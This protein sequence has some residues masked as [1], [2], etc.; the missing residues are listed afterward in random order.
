MPQ[1]DRPR[2]AMRLVCCCNASARVTMVR[3]PVADAEAAP[4]MAAMI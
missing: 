3:P 1:L 2:L 4:S